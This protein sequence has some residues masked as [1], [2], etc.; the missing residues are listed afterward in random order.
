MDNDPR[1]LRGHT[2]PPR[3]LLVVDDNV[4]LAG[5]TALFAQSIG[6]DVLTLN[7]SD[8]A[9]ETFLSFCPDFVILDLMLPAKDGLAVL[10]EILTTGSSARIILTSGLPDIRQR[11]AARVPSAAPPHVTVLRKPYCLDDLLAVLRGGEI[12]VDQHAMVS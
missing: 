7:S 1:G 8:R 5:A 6:F 9:I 10:Q 4:L 2:G 11:L 12:G 3:K